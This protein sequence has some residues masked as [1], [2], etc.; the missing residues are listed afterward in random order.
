METYK[1]IAYINDEN[2]S[3]KSI[4]SIEKKLVL[5]SFENHVNNNK[6]NKD[7]LTTLNFFNEKIKTIPDNYN[8]LDTKIIS[9]KF[10]ELL[11]TLIDKTTVNT[12][13][14]I[15]RLRNIQ[16]SFIFIMIL[17]GITTI[18]NLRIRLFIP[19][20]KLLDIS[21]S[22]QNGNFDKK[23]ITNIN[24]DEMNQLGES[25]NLM[26]DS[27]KN[28]Y[29]N[30]EKVV[31]HKTEKLNKQNKYL[32]FL[33]RT[34]QTFN[35]EKYSCD[36][37]SPLV[38]ELMVLTDIQKINIVILDYQESDQ[39][40]EFQFG[41]NKRPQFCKRSNCY[42]CFDENLTTNKNLV[43]TTRDL[44]DSNQ[45]YGKIELYADA[46]NPLHHDEQQLFIAFSDLL[47]QALSIY[48]K[49][50]QQQQLSLLTERNTIA[51]ELHDSIA[52]S[53]S[54]LKIK[55]SILQMNKDNLHSEQ[56]KI[57]QEMRNEVNSAYSQLRELLTTFRLKIDGLG[58]MPALEKTISE[59]NDKLNLIINFKYDIPANTISTH[60]SIHLLQIIREILNN[61][62]KH[63]E[64]S[65]VEVNLSVNG[66]EISLF[67]NDDGCGFSSYEENSH[68]GLKIIE[69]RAQS[70]S[71]EWNIVS[72]PNQGTQFY[73]TFPILNRE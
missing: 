34:C 52:Q 57:I 73:L 5:P 72:S 28:M 24:K 35:M 68:Y 10:I 53:L 44:H 67:V 70:L 6:L 69:D 64:A 13:K 3:L 9:G 8:N 42:L 50:Q 45:H 33:Y 14:S 30:L 40:Q 71:G 55:I 2:A 18:I 31:Q 62:Y 20:K 58:F 63:A 11:N 59:Y 66:H 17:F 54:C 49:D 36:R 7:Y 15:N 27:L 37:L 16:Y 51:R 21:K 43:K 26:S 48:Y 22:I 29:I 41:S 25:I 39:I 61:V 1:L 4:Y 56:E 47:T 60:Q 46:N 38:K 12:E 65:K 32:D 19:W 23:F